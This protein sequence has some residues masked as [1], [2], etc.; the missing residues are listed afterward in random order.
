MKLKEQLL[1]TLRQEDC[2]VN[3]A[4]LET[5]EFLSPK[6]TRYKPSTVGRALRLLSEEDGRIAKRIQGKSIAYRYQMNSYELFH[7]ERR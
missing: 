7:K 5:M 3:S 4:A 2:W 1:S 6:G